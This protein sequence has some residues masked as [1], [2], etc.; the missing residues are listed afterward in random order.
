MARTKILASRTTKLLLIATLTTL[1][2]RVA[3]AAS[4]SAAPQ[5]RF[6]AGDGGVQGSFGQ[7]TAASAN[8]LAVGANQKVAA[9]QW[10]DKKWQVLP[11]IVPAA[12]SGDGFGEAIAAGQTIIAVGAPGVAP[13]GV[14]S[15]FS[16]SG[17]AWQAKSTIVPPGGKA[18]D[19]FGAA[20][21]LDGT[22]LVVGAPSRDA[23]SPGAAY[24][25]D[26]KYT[27]PGVTKLT[28][29]VSTAGAHFGEAVAISGGQ[30]V[31]GAP[32]DNVEGTKVGTAYVFVERG[33]RWLEAS[34]LAW[35]EA[36][37]G[38]GFGSAVAVTADD[39]LVGAPMAD[40]GATDSGIVLTFTRSA[41]GWQPTGKLA[42][43]DNDAGG[44]F[45]TSLAARG[46]VALVGAPLDDS[47]ARRAGA[48]HFYI[49]GANWAW[50]RKETAS[51]ATRGAAFGAT[52]ALGT[53]QAVV[54]APLSTAAEKSVGVVYGL[55][56]PSGARAVALPTETPTAVPTATPPA[57]TPTKVVVPAT[58]GPPPATPTRA[59]TKTVAAP[60]Q[61]AAPTEAAPRCGNGSV[62]PGEACDPKAS[63]CCSARCTFVEDGG[64]CDDGSAST[65]KSICI[66]HRCGSDVVAIERPAPRY[67]ARAS[68]DQVSG[69]VR[70]RFTVTAAGAVEDVE[71]VSADPPRYFESAATETVSKYKYKPRM[72]NGVAVA[73][74]GVEVV[75]N[76]QLAR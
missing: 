44:S 53:A 30:I 65:S 16:F 62:D 21:A 38:D 26:L 73:R 61:A 15:L 56:L 76:F 43:P 68:R 6:T 31:V 57:D 74:R 51:D 41:T 33:G 13:A 70:L 46:N 72:E 2:S 42:R 63:A 1:A 64:S 55:E 17:G 4:D 34:K 27:P 60:T 40:D 67:P 49:R 54:S 3:S 23:A 35:P 36:R 75:L 71:V 50:I 19:R 18:Q 20:M 37:A 28:S 48:A 25:V 66:N 8:F 58:A 32:R 22:T 39:I 5:L 45:G 52:V 9:W 14:V 47:S 7:S 11:P 24:V 12:N 59:P 69:V 29:T 10:Q